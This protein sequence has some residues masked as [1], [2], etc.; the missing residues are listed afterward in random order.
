[1]MTNAKKRF[2]YLPEG[3]WVD[4]QNGKTYSSGWQSIPAGEIPCVILV[5]K[6]AVIPHIPLAQSTSEMDWTKVYNV[7]Y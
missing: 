3:K 1:M 7:R 5:R 4:Y 2:V 6:G